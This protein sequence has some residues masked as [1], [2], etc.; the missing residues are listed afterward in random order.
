[1]QISTSRGMESPGCLWSQ[2]DAKEVVYLYR[3]FVVVILV[4]EFWYCFGIGF[5]FSLLS[6]LLLCLM[7]CSV[8][9]AQNKMCVKLRKTLTINFKVGGETRC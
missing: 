6:V 2:L 3:C 9:H 5:S 4:C 8:N 7:F 1:M